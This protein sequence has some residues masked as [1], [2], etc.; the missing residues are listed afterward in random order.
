M[1]DAMRT[2]SLIVPTPAW[3]ALFCARIMGW[4]LGDEMLIREE[5]EGLRTERLWTTSSATGSVR[6][7]EW[8]GR[9]AETLG[10]RYQ[11]ELA[12]HYR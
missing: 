3:Y 2:F 10:R 12:R 4:F 11:S 8:V 1:R 6:F 5:V 9:H 7:S